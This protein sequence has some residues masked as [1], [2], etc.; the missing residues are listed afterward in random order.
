MS[1]R[2]TSVWTDVHS[3]LLGVVV[4]VAVVSAVAA[5]SGDPRFT[6][7][8]VLIAVATVMIASLTD[9]LGGMA[10]A[11]VGGAATTAVHDL[12]GTGQLAGFADQAVRLG[13]LLIV[14]ACAGSL[15][16]RIRRGRRVAERVAAQAVAPVEGT[17]GLISF[18]D[19]QWRLEEE[20]LRA[21]LHDRPL[22]I[23]QVTV[24][25]EDDSLSEDDRVRAMRAVARTLETELRSTDVPFVIGEDSFGI[26]LPESSAETAND[27]IEP[28]LMLSRL[29]TFTDRTSGERRLVCDVADVRVAIGSLRRATPPRLAAAPQP[30]TASQ[31]LAAPALV[32]DSAEQPPGLLKAS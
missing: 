20:K 5:R 21:Q 6:L 7:G 22:S 16:D 10:V 26:I 25:I 11:L 8:T 14:G 17:L 4:V 13:L 27:V 19:A 18:S 29:A 1:R 32:D 28:A 15:G 2:L 12:I 24:R 30:S 3:S 31:L 9:S 23:A